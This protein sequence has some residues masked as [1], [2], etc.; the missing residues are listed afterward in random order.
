MRHPLD[1]PHPITS[2]FYDPRSWGQHAAS[3]YGV[4]LKPCYAS[5]DG[6]AVFVGWAGNGG[7][8]IEL[9]DSKGLRTR[10]MHLQ[11]A[12]VTVGQAVKEGQQIGVTGNSTNIVGGV[13]YHLHYAIWLKTKE[14]ALKIQPDPYLTQGWYAV[15]PEL[16]LAMVPPTVSPPEE[17][18]M[19]MQF[20]QVA[21]PTPDDPMWLTDGVS[22]KGI[23]TN[24]IIVDSVNLGFAEPM[25][26][27]LPKYVAREYVEWLD[28]F[29][30][31]HE[32]ILDAVG[33]TGAHDHDG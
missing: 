14:A 11:S 31:T 12:D 23:T 16:Y 10:Y 28:D 27:G 22:K 18:D 8:T 4:A 7:T 3:D 15:D 9:E 20:I 17:E 30:A 2:G 5:H 21:N 29:P 25:T 19:K 26:N 1:E 32:R 24:Q 6:K 33:K 13:G